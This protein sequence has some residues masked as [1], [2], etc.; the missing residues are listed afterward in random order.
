MRAAPQ[1]NDFLA[2][3]AV[4]II[5]RTA[6]VFELSASMG[7]LIQVTSLPVAECP[8]AVTGGMQHTAN[9]RCAAALLLRR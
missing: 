2:V 9:H 3:A 7:P 1:A 4:L 8:S 6:S 5:S